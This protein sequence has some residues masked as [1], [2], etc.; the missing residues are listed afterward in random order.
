[1]PRDPQPNHTPPSRVQRLIERANDRDREYF[2]RNPSEDAYIRPY[3]PGECFPYHE[4]RATHVIV[5][6]LGP[7]IRTRRP[8][9]FSG[10]DV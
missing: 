2:Q 10:G 1:M 9:W 8:V 5:T 4:P 3:V 6:R 7:G